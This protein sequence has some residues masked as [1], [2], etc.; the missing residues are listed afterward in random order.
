MVWVK[1]DDSALTSPSWLELPRAARLLHL[2]ALSWS[3]RHGANG[4]IPRSARALIT[5]EPEAAAMAGLLVDVGAWVVT[6]AGWQLVWLLEDQPTAEEQEHERARWRERKERNRR[7]HRGDHSRCNPAWCPISRRDSRRESTDDAKRDPWLESRSP[8]P[9]PT[10]PDQESGSVED[11]S[12]AD[13]AEP[14]SRT[15]VQQIASLRAFLEE[16]PDA[17][18]AARRAAEGTLHRLEREAATS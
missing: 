7:H 18:L 2:E 3:N 6:D 12:S 4:V 16:N 15:R 17:A 11:G 8:A 1:L 10:R 13:Q 5:D 14:S 9:T